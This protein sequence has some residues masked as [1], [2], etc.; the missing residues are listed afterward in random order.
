MGK[1]IGMKKGGGP[2]P[3]LGE[4]ESC[5]INGGGSGG[6]SGVVGLELTGACWGRRACFTPV[7]F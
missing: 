3:L 7:A 6:R 2:V 4:K 1:G 5:L